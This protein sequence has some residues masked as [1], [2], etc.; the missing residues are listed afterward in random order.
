MTLSVRLPASLEQKLTA[1]CAAHHVSRSEA[2]KEALNRFLS[3]GVPAKSYLV[4]SQLSHQAIG[5]GG[6]YAPQSRQR[7]SENILCAEGIGIAFVTTGYTQKLLSAAVVLSRRATS[8]TFPRGIGRI[9][10]DK[11]NTVRLRGV[12]DPVEHLA[13][14]PRRDCLTKRLPAAFLLA[15]L[16]VVQGFHT[17]HG[18]IGSV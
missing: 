8:E 5:L 4:D 7:A 3:E 12:L 1:Y 11:P 2:I 6:L 9:D 14:Y 10:A 13:V 16:Q 18:G 17:Q 15:A